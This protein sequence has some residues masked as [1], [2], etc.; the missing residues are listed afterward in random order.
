[1]KK[2]ILF[3]LLYFSILPFAQAQR[4]YAQ[5]FFILL[6]QEKYFEAREFKKQYASQLSQHKALDLMYDIHISLEFN[7]PD[8]AIV[9]LEEF[10]GNQD[11]IQVLGPLIATY[12]SRLSGVYEEKQ[13]FGH[14]ISTIERHIAYLERNPY[15]MDQDF[16][17]KEIREARTKIS[18]LKEKAE[19][20]PIRRIKRDSD[21]CGIELKDGTHIRFDAKYN[22]QTVET[23]F[24]TGSSY[25]FFIEKALADDLGVKYRPSQ[26]LGLLNGSPANLFEGII[27]SV[28]LKGVKLYDIPVAVFNG[29]Y[30]SNMPDNLNADQIKNIEEH[31]LKNR[32]IVMGLPA[33]KMIG[34]F[35]FDWKSNVLCLPPRQESV[36]I[37][38]A[39]NFMIIKNIPY[40]N[41]K[42]NDVGFTGHFDTGADQ[43][44]FLTNTYFWSKSTSLKFEDAQ[45]H[46]FTRVG[47][48]GV[49]EVERQRVKSPHIYFDGR[50]IS[51]SNSDSEVYALDLVWANLNSFDGEV[52]VKF[53]KDFYSKCIIDFDAMTIECED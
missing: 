11:Y 44:L 23:F 31:F 2:V 29:K 50:K 7:K 53:I 6:Y 38:P 13:Q 48:T 36:G 30:L 16:V 12:Y 25:F 49:H 17:E 34:R 22:G 21:A 27:D 5:E 35:E 24:D 33:M 3:I 32:Q 42:I 8:S 20:E 41:I 14:S 51:N 19:N 28:E 52:G 43:F 1:M 9:Y 37:S 18:S 15:S 47:F 46:P 26:D 39:S 45:K 10:L 4:N 40:L